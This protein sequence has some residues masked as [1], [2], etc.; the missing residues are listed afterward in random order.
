MVKGSLCVFGLWTKVA[1][2]E[3]EG[4]RGRRMTGKTRSSVGVDVPEGAKV[5]EIAFRSYG[6]PLSRYSFRILNSK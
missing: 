1:S 6:S 4:K 5:D 3:R 2:S